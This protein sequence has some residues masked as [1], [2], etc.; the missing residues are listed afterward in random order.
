MTPERFDALF[1]TFHATAVRLE[2]LPAYDVAG[3]EGSRLAAF[4]AGA[5]LP[6]RSVRTD[7]W[8]A[9]I[10]RTSTAG[11]VWQRVR[12]VDEPLTDYERFELAVY[13]ETQAVGEEIVVVARPDVEVDGPDFWLLDA[14]TPDAH[15]VL[16][17]YNERGEWRGA[18]LTRDQDVLEGSPG[19]SHGRWHGRCR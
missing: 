1:D 3:Y 19:G 13:P 8:L 16:M 12:V 6:V 2:T 14:G 15:D 10:A 17:R 9:R 18:E 4:L 11:K 5:A 7:P